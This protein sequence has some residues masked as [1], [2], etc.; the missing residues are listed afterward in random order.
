M[1]LHNAQFLNLLLTHSLELI[2][3]LDYYIY[4][5]YKLL[6]IVCDVF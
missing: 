4:D 5:I 6:E 3:Y 1:A 2:R